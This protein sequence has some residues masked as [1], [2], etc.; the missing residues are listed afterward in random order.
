M[1]QND[2][3]HNM[4]HQFFIRTDIGPQQRV[5]PK[6]HAIICTSSTAHYQ[7]HIAPSGRHI[8]TWNDLALKGSEIRWT[9]TAGRKPLKN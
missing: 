9:P 2:E 4:S 7:L 5:D 1:S 6:L 3:S 8:A